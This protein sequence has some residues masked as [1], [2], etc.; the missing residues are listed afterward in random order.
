MPE[1]VVEGKGK[2]PHC[3]FIGLGAESD[4]HSG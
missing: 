2:L 3:Q 1:S 4:K